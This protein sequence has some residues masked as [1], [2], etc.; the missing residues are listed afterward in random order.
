MALYFESNCWDYDDWFYIR[1]INKEDFEFALK[2]L[3]KKGYTTLNG[4]PITDIMNKNLYYPFIVV[5]RYEDNTRR[6]S[7]SNVPLF[8]PYFTDEL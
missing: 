2:I 3:H 8:R 7:F 1:V 5:R 4:D 6:I